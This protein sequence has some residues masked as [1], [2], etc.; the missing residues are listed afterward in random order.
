MFWTVTGVTVLPCPIFISFLFLSKLISLGTLLKFEKPVFI[1]LCVVFY[2]K[3]FLMF[4]IFLIITFFI[5]YF[6]I[7]LDILFLGT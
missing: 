2:F 6:F 7:L 3:M 1:R 5:F 4:L